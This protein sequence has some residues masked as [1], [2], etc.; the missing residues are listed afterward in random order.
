MRPILVLAV[1]T[2]IGCGSSESS[3]S[4]ADATPD[5]T[6]CFYATTCRSSCD[7]PITHSGC[8]VT[9]GP[10]EV[11]QI[12][13]H[14]DAATDGAN[15]AATDAKP[16]EAGT[17]CV[18]SSWPTAAT[19]GIPAGTPTLTV[20]ADSKHTEKDGQI[21]DAVELQGRLYVDHKN[22][23]IRRSRL[24]GDMYYAVYTTIAD[25]N[26]TIEDSDIVGGVLLTDHFV[27]RRNHLHA[28]AG[29]T[30]DDGWIFAASDVLLEDNLID[31]LIGDMGAHLDGIQIMGGSRIVLRH[32]WIEA[33]SPPISGGG[34]N[35]AIFFAPD[36][37]PIADV[38]VECNMLIE[39]DGYYPLRIDSKAPIVV[40]KNRWQK[41][42]LGAPVLITGDAVTTWEDNAYDDGEVIPKP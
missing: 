11:D 24:I 28:P 33:K 2:V 4:S 25:S 6:E 41:G 3:N 18:P 17:E 1:L 31:G 7:G 39:K 40:R 32:N 15:E 12:T 30:R 36:K 37:G 19:T 20:I 23:V 29:G 38:T 42:H 10:G 35:A 16:S 27:G 22:V 9:C 14:S 8:G 26:L 13:C 21:L 5:I 34:V